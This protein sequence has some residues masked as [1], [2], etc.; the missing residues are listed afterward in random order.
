MGLSI[1]DNFKI[2]KPMGKVY[3]TLIMRFKYKDFFKMDF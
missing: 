2:N 1:R 3:Y